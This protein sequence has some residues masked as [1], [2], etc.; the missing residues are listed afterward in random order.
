MHGLSCRHR[1][2]ARAERINDLNYIDFVLGGDLE[3]TGL[4]KN[5]KLILKFLEVKPEMTTKELAELVF[6]KPVEY[7][8]KEYSSIS[9]SLQSLE[10][11]GLVKRVQIQLRWKLTK[12]KL[13]G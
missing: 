9:R 11:R 8:T 6:G 1:L 13:F 4:S 12:H 7:K 10:R 2:L 3:T 5:Q